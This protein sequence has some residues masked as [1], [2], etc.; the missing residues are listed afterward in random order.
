MRSPAQ[1][2]LRVTGLA[3]CDVSSHSGVSVS[4]CVW[5]LA[6]G[7]QINKPLTRE[8]G[9]GRNYFF[10]AMIYNSARPTIW[11]LTRVGRFL[12]CA[13]D[14]CKLLL[15]EPNIMRSM[16]GCVLQSAERKMVSRSRQ[17]RDRP[18]AGN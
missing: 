6:R 15:I 8:M 14:Q 13:S 17:I 3:D 18:L 1:C 5:Q 9:K 11:P 10:A 12:P 2:R 16:R 7:R 4:R